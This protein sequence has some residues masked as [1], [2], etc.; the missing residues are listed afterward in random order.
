MFLLSFFLFILGE[1]NPPSRPNITSCNADCVSLA[2][3]APDKDGGSPVTHYVVECREANTS[4]WKLVNDSVV[5]TDLS[6]SEGLK[7]DRSYEFRVFAENKIGRSK[8]SLS[9]DLVCCRNELALIRGLKDEEFEKLPQRVLLE[10]ELSRSNCKVAWSHNGKKL[11]NGRKYDIKTDGK[12]YSL[13]VNDFVEEDTGCYEMTVGPINTAA[14]MKLCIAPKVKTDADFQSERCVRVGQAYVVEVPFEGSPKP[15][16]KWTFN[17]G[18]LPDR[19]RYNVDVIHG[20][21]S[22]SVS[23]AEKADAGLLTLTLTNELA[24]CTL[25]ITVRVLDRPSAPLNLRPLSTDANEICLGWDAPADTGGCPL[26]G[27]GVEYRSANKRTWT[28]VEAVSPDK[29]SVTLSGLTE[30]QAY[31]VKVAA[32]NEV[33]ISEPAESKQPIA[34][35]PSFGE[36]AAVQNLFS[37]SFHASALQLLPSLSTMKVC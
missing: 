25:S 13:V 7:E 36:P 35:K 22:L 21:T 26:T 37:C 23:K 1:P 33:G 19:R 17:D 16:V 12:I 5:G 9:T 30:N 4:L 34:A 3:K 18:A 27:Y 10:C 2:W 11:I 29:T 24:K 8:P 28:A 32:V 6:I 15:Q 20:M 14:E 31:H